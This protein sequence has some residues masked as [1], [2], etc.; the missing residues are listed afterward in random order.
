[1]VGD[2]SGPRNPGIDSKS[3][4]TQRGT[5]LISGGDRQASR[6]SAGGSAAETVQLSDEARSIAELEAAAKNA[7]GVDSAKVASAKQAI[8]SGSY[9]LNAERLAGKLLGLDSELYD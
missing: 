5:P 2:I 3:T 4:Q 1:M 8:E 6:T 9:E 7:S